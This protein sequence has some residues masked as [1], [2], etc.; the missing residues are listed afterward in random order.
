MADAD[1][2]ERE[3]WPDDMTATLDY[4]A[5][6][7]AGDRELARW[8]ASYVRQSA[9]PGAAAQL[10]RMNTYVD[11]RSMYATV[12]S[13]LSLSRFLT[14]AEIGCEDATDDARRSTGTFLTQA[15]LRQ[16]KEQVAPIAHQG[17]G[18]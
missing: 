8:F 2:L 3:G 6:S 14:A 17:P 12:F 15:R 5:P 11:V 9:S 13:L 10:L 16:G 7:I 4:Y 1:T 18:R